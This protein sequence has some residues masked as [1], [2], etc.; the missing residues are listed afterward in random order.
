M[1]VNDIEE[2]YRSI[3]NVI[4]NP[5]EPIPIHR[6]FAGDSRWV[7]LMNTISLAR[8]IV[9]TENSDNERYMWARRILDGL[10]TKKET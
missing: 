4:P 10:I 2:L 5:H 3:P 6:Q 1:E 9:R 8:E 7:K